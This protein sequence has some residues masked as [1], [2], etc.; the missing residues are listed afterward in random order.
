M[1]HRIIDLNSCVL[2]YVCLYHQSFQKQLLIDTQF[3]CQ[4]V[5]SPATC[6]SKY[7][8]FESH[9]RYFCSIQLSSG[10]TLPSG[11]DSSCVMVLLFSPSSFFFS[12]LLSPSSSFFS[13]WSLPGTISLERKT[14]P[15]CKSQNTR[16]SVVTQT[17]L[18]IA[19]LTGLE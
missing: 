2:C 11:P 5:H 18:E 3:T 13:S 17:S 12:L 7:L 10:T 1:K 6:S 19:P 4:T 15:D 9:L 8:L 14:L 16:K